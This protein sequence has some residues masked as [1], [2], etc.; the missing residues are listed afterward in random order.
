MSA[1]AIAVQNQAFKALDPVRLLDAIEST[2]IVADGRALALNSY[3]NRV[4]QVG[5]ENDEPLIAKFYRP[6][7]WSDDSILEEHAYTLELAAEELPVIAPLAFA[8]RT[9]ATTGLRCIRAAAAGPR[10]SATPNSWH[11]SVVSLRAYIMSAPA[12]NSCTGPPWMST[13]IASNRRTT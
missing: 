11:S 6:G 9:S 12:A 1:S 5:V 7:R 4:Y 10:I 8:G 3:E 2:G 13:T